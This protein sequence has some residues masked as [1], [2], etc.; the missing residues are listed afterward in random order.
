MRKG[1][2]TKFHIYVNRQGKQFTSNCRV[3]TAEKMNSD[4][5][6]VSKLRNGV[7]NQVKGWQYLGS[8]SCVEIVLRDKKTMEEHTITSWEDL[9][10]LGYKS[11]SSWYALLDRSTLR[12]YD[13]ISKTDIANAE[14]RLIELN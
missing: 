2:S 8:V 9:K 1:Y 3:L 14:P 5:F 10:A 12:G 7:R 11:K 6:E 13:T 4:V